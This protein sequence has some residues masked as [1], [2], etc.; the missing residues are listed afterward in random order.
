M[1]PK[2]VWPEVQVRY[3]RWQFLHWR[4]I[5]PFLVMWYIMYTQTLCVCYCCYYRVDTRSKNGDHPPFSSGLKTVL[6][7]TPCILYRF[8]IQGIIIPY[9]MTDNPTMKIL[10]APGATVSHFGDEDWTASVAS[11]NINLEDI[12][13]CQLT[14]LIV[15]LAMQTKWDI[16]H[17]Q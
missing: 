15:T 13:V 2:S 4:S 7:D 6:T 8:S 5:S 14:P 3:S 16:M 12:H 11:S 9:P 17:L 10:P 1:L